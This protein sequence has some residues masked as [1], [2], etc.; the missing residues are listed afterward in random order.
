MHLQDPPDRRLGLWRVAPCDL[1]K[2]TAENRVRVC[3]N[4]DCSLTMAGLQWTSKVTGTHHS[5][6]G[7]RSISVILLGSVAEGDSREA[8]GSLP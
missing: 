7:Q 5:E 1:P 6:T 3:R 4:L 8:L 2:S